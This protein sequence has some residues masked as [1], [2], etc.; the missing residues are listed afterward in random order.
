M[1][2]RSATPPLSTTL[3]TMT[4]LTPEAI[5]AEIDYRRA[6]ARC[7]WKRANGPSW[8]RRVIHRTSRKHG[9]A[10]G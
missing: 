6:T 8:I 7:N 10:R 3:P 4:E 5:R 2:T 1:I 9:G